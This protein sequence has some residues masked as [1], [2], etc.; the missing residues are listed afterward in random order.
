MFSKRVTGSRWAGLQQRRCGQFTVSAHGGPRVTKMVEDEPLGDRALGTDRRC[1]VLGV[2][3]PLAELA[4]A[5]P[6][7]RSRAMASTRRSALVDLRP[8]LALA[9]IGCLAVSDPRAD[10]SGCTSRVAWPSRHRRS[11]SCSVG[12][13]PLD[14]VQWISS[15]RATS[16]SACRTS[17]RA[18]DGLAAHLAVF[19]DRAGVT[20]AGYHKSSWWE[21]GL[22]PSIPTRLPHFGP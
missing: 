10:G 22:R 15:A 18:R 21:W 13:A 14:G 7:E 17:H 12:D 9:R 5:V 3:A 16:C 11:R 6:G 4:V 8:E 20:L 2:R 19:N 1:G